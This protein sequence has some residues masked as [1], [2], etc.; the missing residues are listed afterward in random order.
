[1]SAP[2][3]DDSK[4]VLIGTLNLASASTITLSYGRPYDVVDLVFV[5]AAAQTS[6]GSG[7]TVGVRNE[8]GSSSVTKAT[9]TAPV[10]AVNTVY[11]AHVAGSYASPIT[12]S[13]EH[14]Q[15]AGVTTGRIDGY[16]TSLPGE[17]QVNP[18][19]QFFVTSSTAGAGGSAK[20]YATIREEGGQ[21][22]RFNPTDL[23]VTL[24]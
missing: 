23:T 4:V 2:F 21:L 16:Q 1:M 15:V 7:I 24:S 11:R 8:D 18:G 9:F 10:G 13:G 19:Q 22:S 17:V 5:Y 20:V 3:V 14:S 6:A 12:P